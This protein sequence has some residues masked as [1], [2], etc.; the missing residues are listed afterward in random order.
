MAK[1]NWKYG[2]TSREKRDTCT[3]GLIRVMNL[4]LELSPVDIAIVWGWRGEEVQNGMYRSG[5]SKKQWPESKHNAVDS[6]GRAASQAFDFAPYLNGI[7][8]DDTHA[9]AMVAGVFFAAAKDLGVTLRWGGDWD[10]DGS[11][12]DQSFMDWGH[13]EEVIYV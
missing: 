4:G 3:P 10:M 1:K 9:F 7:P 12:T 8:W 13:M 5:V 6:D 11:T 2:A